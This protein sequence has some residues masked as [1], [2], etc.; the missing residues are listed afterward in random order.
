MA[1][2]LGYGVND[3]VGSPALVLATTVGVVTGTTIQMTGGGLI[4][5]AGSTVAAL[6]VT[7]PQNAVDGAVAEITSTGTITSFTVNAATSYSPQGLAANQSGT[8]S[9]VIAA[10]VLGTL[11]ALTPAAA[12]TAGGATA[13][14]RFKYSLNGYTNPA[15]GVV[16]N[17]RT[18]FRVS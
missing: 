8:V 11:T 2:Q 1:T 14:V 7:L 5:N 12:T 3:T 13:T 6:T 10:G 16:S 18:W 4:L 9:D 17:A 15:T